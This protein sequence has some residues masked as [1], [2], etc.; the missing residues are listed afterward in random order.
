[1]K[2]ASQVFL[3]HASE[4]KQKVLEVYTRLRDEGFKP[5]IDKEDLLPGQF[6]EHE[7]PKAIKSSDFVILFLSKTS[8]SKRGYVQK[9]VKLALDVLDQSPEGRIFVIP[10]RLDD[11]EVPER[12][13]QLH[14]CNLFENDGW[15]RILKAI[16]TEIQPKD[17]GQTVH[18]NEK[19][20]LIIEDDPDWRDIIQRKM[21]QHPCSIE[22]AE[23]L[24]Q[25]DQKFRKGRLPKYSLIILDPIMDINLGIM[26][27]LDILQYASECGAEVPVIIISGYHDQDELIEELKPYSQMV[28][29]RV[30]SKASFDSIS[31]D[32]TVGELLVVQKTSQ[33][34][35]SWENLLERSI[36]AFCFLKIDLQTHGASF[37]RHH[38][39]GVS[40]TLDSFETFIEDKV[41]A[42]RGRVWSWQG[43]G[44]LCGFVI[45]DCVEDAVLCA[46]DIFGSFS[47][48][49]ANPYKNRIGE[50]INLRVAVHY[51]PAKYHHEKGRIHS[52][53]INFVSHLEAK[54]AKT[55][56]VC[57]SSDAWKESTPLIRSK[58]EKDLK[59][60]EVRKF[61]I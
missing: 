14:W 27:G 50:T 4:D 42:R 31:F 37:E 19:I 15:D 24:K 44:G 23:N 32:R 51:G 26:A 36:Y 28:Q 6:W 2:R 10:V 47:E 29:G 21:D 9:E 61:F 49:N 41:T 30:F 53:A 39:K 38:I 54:K 20:V 11:C 52:E 40:E 7:I 33:L 35:P 8:V 55:N 34:G 58:F 46:I 3:C 13:R 18:Q 1:M 56:S 48:F 57:I 60:F 43:H 25:V 17:I 12:F 16:S 59:K 45:P 5:W 22:V